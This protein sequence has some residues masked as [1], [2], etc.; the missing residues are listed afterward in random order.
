MTM[1][2]VVILLVLLDTILGT[3]VAM[4]NHN[5]RSAVGRQ[6]LTK[7]VA[8]VCVISIMYLVSILDSEHFPP[9]LVSTLYW[10]FAF[11]EFTSIAE[12]LN[13]L[14]LISDDLLHTLRIDNEEKKQKNKKIDS[15]HKDQ[16]INKK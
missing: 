2:E 11:F 6:D 16:N 14:G 10:A 8:E 3:L 13:L 15:D 4:K 7:K 5:L 1:I 12:N 9:D